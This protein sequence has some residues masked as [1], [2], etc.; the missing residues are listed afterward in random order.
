[1]TLPQ[2]TVVPQVLLGILVL[3]APLTIITLPPLSP[4]SPT[5]LP[6]L[7]NINVWLIV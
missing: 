6:P 5:L 1:M 2:V 7:P 3:S 4:L